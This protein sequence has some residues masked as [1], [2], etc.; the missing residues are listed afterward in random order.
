METSATISLG[1]DQ[2]EFTYI[3]IVYVNVCATCKLNLLLI[4]EYQ[5]LYSTCIYNIPMQ[6]SVVVHVTCIYV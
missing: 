6:S 1:R 2:S 5:I 3:I 4:R